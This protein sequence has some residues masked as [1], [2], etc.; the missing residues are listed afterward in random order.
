MKADKNEEIHGFKP[1]RAMRYST[2]KSKPEKRR[3]GKT[4]NDSIH[5]RV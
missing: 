4:C 5:V 2:Q 3:L 1:K